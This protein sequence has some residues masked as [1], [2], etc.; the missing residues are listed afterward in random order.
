MEQR[1]L[2]VIVDPKTPV[3]K[4]TRYVR[5]HLA[6][7]GYLVRPFANQKNS[8]KIS[9]SLKRE[10]RG[11]R[12]VIVDLSGLPTKLEGNSWKY[13]ECVL[14]SVENA[15]PLFLVDEDDSPGQSAVLSRAIA[16]TG[17]SNN[18][19]FRNEHDYEDAVKVEKILASLPYPQKNWLLITSLA[20]SATLLLLVVGFLMWPFV[21]AADKKPESSQ[22]ASF[23]GTNEAETTKLHETGAEPTKIQTVPAIAENKKG[24]KKSETPD[25]PPGLVP[26]PVGYPDYLSNS[27]ILLK[28]GKKDQA[29]AVFQDALAKVGKDDL[30]FFHDYAE[31]LTKTGGPE[32]ATEVFSKILADHPEWPSVALI[33]ILRQNSTQKEPAKSLEAIDKLLARHPGYTPGILAGVFLNEKSGFILDDLDLDGRAKAFVKTGGLES[34]RK[35]VPNYKS[36]P[37]L[38]SALTQWEATKGPKI[39]ERLAFK[40]DRNRDISLLQIFIRDPEQPKSVTL[41]FPSGDVLISDP[42]VSAKTGQAKGFVVELPGKPPEKTQESPVFKPRKTGDNRGFSHVGTLEGID[43]YQPVEILASY[44]D[45]KNRPFRFPQTFLIFGKTQDFSGDVVGA[46]SKSIPGSPTRPTL[47]IRSVV[48]VRTVQ[49][50]A[51]QKV[52]FAKATQHPAIPT[53]FEI[54]CDK[55]PFFK[56]GG[57]VWIRSITDNNDL[58]ENIQIRP[59][60][61]LNL[62]WETFK[63]TNNR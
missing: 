31:A 63:P 5:K 30:E 33:Q 17:Q 8:P 51:D 53:L 38:A 57:Q 29:L 24:T 43:Q 40:I 9:E 46:G 49:V 50:S 12:D 55:V 25:L 60:N 28:A 11:C 58:L 42:I 45:A 37:F 52:A 35:L 19:I 54:E 32:K 14:D 18:L 22:L 1:D 6:R 62:T 2:V 15:I 39:D 61:N 4:G 59:T 44:V 7:R 23:T 10:L 16:L 3:G 26:I 48:G 20:V 47:V 36:I 27:R 56:P 13:L 34:L 21:F 41:H